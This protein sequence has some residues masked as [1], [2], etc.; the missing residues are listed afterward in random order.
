MGLDEAI[1][2]FKKCIEVNA[3]YAPAYANIAA[4]EFKNENYKEA[5]KNADKAIQLDPDY[6]SAYV[7]RGM[8]R[9]ML[10]DMNGACEDWNKAKELGAE[11]G[12]Q[13]YSQ[14]CGF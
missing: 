1:E 11:T 2:D 6:A 14:N 5:K 3:N 7:N 12:G 4:A 13:Y 10:R 8:I 9:E